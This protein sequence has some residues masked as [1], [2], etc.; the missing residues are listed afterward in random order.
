MEKLLNGIIRVSLVLVVF[1]IPLVWSP[2]TAEHF[3]F[4]K[5]YLAI[6]L[7]F[8][9]II[10]WLA[11][12]VLVDGEVRFKRTPLDLPILIF[13]VVL[14]VS[15]VFS[16]DRISSLLGYYGRFSDGFLG[17]LAFIGLYVLVV[18]TVDKPSSL[19]GPF[20]AAATLSIAIGYFALFGAFQ[21]TGFNLVAGSTQGFAIFLAFVVVFLA[22]LHVG[23][24]KQLPWA[25][26][27]FLALSAF[28]ILLAFDV[29]Y[30]WIVLVVGLV[31]VVLSGLS[32][33]LWTDNPIRIRVLWLPLVFLL[34]SVIFLFSPTKVPGSQEFSKESVLSKEL[35]FGIAEGVIKE[36]AKNLLVGSGPGTFA[37]DFS[38]YKPEELNQTSQWQ[39]RFDRAGNVFAELLA[40]TGILGFLAYLGLLAWFF[41]LSLMFVKERTSMP[42]VG[43]VAVLVVAQ[44]VYYEITVLQLFFWLF[45]GLS[46]VSWKI[47]HREFR[48][49]LK[50]FPEFHVAAKALLFVLMMVFGAA[51]FLGARF[52]I[53]DMNYFSSQSI[54][55]SSFENKVAK[56]LEAVRLNPWQAEYRIFLSRLYLDRALEEL[57]KPEDITNQEQISRDM[58]LAI[59]YG[60]GDILEGQRI[61]G[62]IQLSPNKV[63][64]WETLG[65]V[66]RDIAFT[67]GALDWGIYSFENALSLEPTNPILHTELGKLYMKGKQ[68]EKARE[69]FEKAVELKPDYPQAKVQ[70]ALLMEQE[71]DAALALATLQEVNL[72]Y[73]LHEEGLFELGRLLYNAGRTKEAIFYFQQILLEA[74][75][76]SNALFSLGV[77]FESEG[78]IPQAIAA[79]EKVLQLNP[80]NTAVEKKLQEL[81]Q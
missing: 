30:S 47:P 13:L 21:Q 23:S 3:E 1:L 17:T 69:H 8:L 37:L 28:G 16:I 10:A 76:H 22:F 51:V 5:Q 48:F 41:L 61:V 43:G 20:L 72:R 45:L 24:E 81:A 19:I 34:L 26:N 57:R 75:N 64:S 50:R 6:F 68:F 29:I 25:G 27:L 11:K 70:L 15:T 55:N 39:V 80:G 32:Q 18:N 67:V 40:T 60:R 31:L 36:G 9:G 2:W 73:S 44:L 66:Y 59:A 78:E 49:A 53:A 77:A 33:R 74:P 62:A 71:G 56:G 14:L 46:V 65:I 63:A 7:V 52:Y 4:S 79:F 42:F 58:Q 54:L 38:R 12:M 35:S